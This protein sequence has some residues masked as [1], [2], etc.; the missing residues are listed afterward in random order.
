MHCIKCQAHM[1]TEQS[2]KWGNVC[3]QCWQKSA[4]AE[5]NRRSQSL[6]R[7][8]SATVQQQMIDDDIRR[9]PCASCG[10]TQQIIQALRAM[11]N[12]KERPQHE[13]DVLSAAIRALGGNP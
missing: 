2:N 7:V 1:S 4:N 9:N 11:T 8:P 6:N 10:N 5:L 13:I 3:A 12:D